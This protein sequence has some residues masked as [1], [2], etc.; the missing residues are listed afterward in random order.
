MYRHEDIK[1]MKEHYKHFSR[2]CSTEFNISI[3]VQQFFNKVVIIVML[4]LLFCRTHLYTG[5]VDKTIRETWY[6]SRSIVSLI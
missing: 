4:L 5:N 3:K 1:D 2:L 6:E